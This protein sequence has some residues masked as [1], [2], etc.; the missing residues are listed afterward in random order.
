MALRAPK[1]GNNNNRVEQPVIEADVYPSYLVQIIDLGL[2]PQKEFQGKAKP[3]CQEIMLTYELSD[4]F[5]LDEEGEELEDKPRWISEVLPFYGLFADKA[6]STQRYKA[7]DPTEEW[8]GD[9]SKALG[10]PCNVTIVN[11]V[12]GDKT[13]TNVANVASISEK[14]AA[15]MNELKNPTKAFDLDEPDLEIFNSLPKWIQDKIK[16]NLEYKGSI[17]EAL[18]E[19]GGKEEK[20]KAD[21]KADAAKGKPQK[22]DPPFD[23]DEDDHPY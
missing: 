4:V 2:Q 11:N 15:K 16:G 21:K 14:K 20:P 10:M 5:M 17:L 8:E 3:P 6:K 18:L 13:Y 12:K 22:E 23:A 9:F 19:N 1:G 7:F